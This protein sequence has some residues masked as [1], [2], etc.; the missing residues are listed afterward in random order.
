MGCK[1]QREYAWVAATL[2]NFPQAKCFHQ[3]GVSLEWKCQPKKGQIAPSK[4]TNF[5]I[6]N[7]SLSVI[8]LCTQI[9]HQQFIKWPGMYWMYWSQYTS[10]P[11]S[12]LAPVWFYPKQGR[13]TGSWLLPVFIQLLPVF[14][15]CSYWQTMCRQLVNWLL[16]DFYWLPADYESQMAVKY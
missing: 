15:Q 3:L 7:M 12:Q 1:P 10:M 9:V 14:I 2:S 5:S 4:T 13:V 11:V 8:V 16:L 6:V